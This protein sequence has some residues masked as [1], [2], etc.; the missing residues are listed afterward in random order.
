MALGVWNSDGNL[1]G[2]A[3]NDADLGLGTSIGRTWTLRGDWKPADGRS[4]YGLRARAVESEQNPISAT[5]PDKPGYTVV[6]LLGRWT[7]IGDERLVLTASINNLFDRFYYDHGTYGYN[8]GAGK[9]IGFASPGR[10]FNVSLTY[11]Y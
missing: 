3:L 1:D 11:R 6:D 9:Y 7:L 2:R 8:A 10:E 5:A 4:Q